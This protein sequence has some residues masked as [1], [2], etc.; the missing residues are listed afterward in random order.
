MKSLLKHTIWTLSLVFLLMACEEEEYK[1]PEV[2]NAFQNDC[3]K[4]SLGPNIVGRTID[5]AY[6]IALPQSLGSIVSAQVEASIPGATGTFLEHRAL[7]SNGGADIPKQIGDPSIT[8]GSLT[9]VTFIRDTFAVTLRYFYAI[10]EEARGQKVSFKFSAR[11]TNGKTVTYNM[12]PYQVSSIDMVLDRQLSD[13]GA[14][15][16]SIADMAVYTA[17]EAAANPDKIDLVY[18]YRTVPNVTFAHALVSPAADPTYLPGITLPAGVNKD[19]KLIKTLNLRDRQLARLQFGIY[20]DDLDF[21]QL[22]TTGA[23]NYAINFRAEA[24]AW[25][26]T[27]DGQYRAF[28]Y[29]NAISNTNRTMTVSIKRLKMF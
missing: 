2:N 9:T 8:E 3:I 16:L 5:F 13:N 6:A 10:P 26:E 23:S 4:R 1:V 18:L 28:V 11:D 17:A 14:M 20:I 22:N 7:S 27:A 12:G 21:T 19:T 25:V 29:V 24:G 15:Y